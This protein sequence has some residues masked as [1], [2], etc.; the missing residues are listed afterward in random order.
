MKK[1]LILLLFPLSLHA[2][3]KNAK[4]PAPAGNQV[5]L[6]C[7][8]IGAPPQT[9]FI[10]LYEQIGLAYREVARGPM[11]AD[12][13]F[14]LTLPAGKARIYSIGFNETMNGR[15]ILGEEKQLTLWANAEYMQK[16]RTVGSP[17][18]TNYLNV[19]KR[20]EELRVAGDQ[21]RIDL[22]LA[23]ANRDDN[24]LKAVNA[25]L[26]ALGKEKKTFLDSLKTANPMLW[27]SATLQISPDYTSDNTAYTGELDFYS[28]QFF[29][30]ADLTDKAYED[31]PDVYDAFQNYVLQ[32][33]Q[34]GA[35]VTASKQ[36][37]E[38]QL[39]KLTPGTNTYRRALA[40]T[41]T[42]LQTGNHPE[43]V[44]FVKRYLD[45]YRGNDL[46]EVGR[47]EF[48]LKKNSTF[49][50]G[51]EA[52]DLVGQTPEGGSYALSKLRG[53][54][55]LVDFWASWCGPCRKE[56]PNVKAMYEKYKAKGFD[57]LGV[58]LDREEGAWKKAI[59]Q[60]GL[61]WR[62]ISDL[63]GW[64]SAHAALYSVSSIPQTLLL[65]PQGK[66]I[67]RNLRGE[68]LAEKLR[69]IFGE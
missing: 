15:I 60:D 13:S 21:L 57:I 6:V 56:N 12:S 51:M 41:I 68:Q 48:E 38:A 36:M 31:I 35:S 53:K 67:Q 49:T 39:A 20:L 3:Q 18:N 52:P 8:I 43:Y 47:L 58:S 10:S 33:S 11:Q 16:G 64:K 65:D 54:V 63:Q 30:Y 61:T 62:H 9:S 59:E 2:F 26:T 19:Q 32:V 24:N 69:E 17:A 7:K 34:L 28:Q 46:G 40:G 25:R 66:I 4:S 22:R 45:T 23:R 5:S 1:L 42:G 37:V 27:R 55:V 44:N 29:G 50:A 14:L